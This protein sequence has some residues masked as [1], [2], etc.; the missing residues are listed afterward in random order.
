MTLF[1]YA[2]RLKSSSLFY[3]KIKRQNFT[4]N[5]IVEKYLLNQD[6]KMNYN[7]FYYS[8]SAKIERKHC[9]R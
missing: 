1:R 3:L 5:E 4:K 8:H 2:G 7:L 9:V 6:R